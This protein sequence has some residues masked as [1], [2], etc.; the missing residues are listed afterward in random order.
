MELKE[1]PNALY[2]FKKTRSCP[3]LP[4]AE[5]FRKAV[6]SIEAAKK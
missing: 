1:Y 4:D 5:R 2:N 3:D 6:S